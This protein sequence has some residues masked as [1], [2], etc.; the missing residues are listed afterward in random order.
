MTQKLSF[1]DYFSVDDPFT[2]DIEKPELDRI[3]RLY[4]AGEAPKD[5]E[6]IPN[7]QKYQKERICKL[8]RF[9]NLLKSWDKG[10][11]E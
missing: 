3:G 4:S 11:I 8:V 6:P 1:L 7:H 5:H 10:M 9:E 2:H